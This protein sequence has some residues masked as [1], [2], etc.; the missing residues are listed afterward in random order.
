ESGTYERLADAN[1]RAISG[2]QPKI[3]T[4]NTGDH[5]NSSSDSMAPIRNIM[6]GLPPILSTIHE[7]TGIAPPSWFAEMP[8]TKDVNG[9]PQE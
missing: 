4:W 5:G 1:G 6:Q 8:K 3:T 2:L 9:K 7:Q